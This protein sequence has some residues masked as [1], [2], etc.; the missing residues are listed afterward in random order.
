MS[1]GVTE[2]GKTFVRRQDS[3]PGDHVDLL[4]LFD[5]L[6]VPNV[7]GSDLMKTSNYSIKAVK[8]S[9]FKATAADLAKVPPVP[10]GLASQRTPKDFKIKNIKAE[11]E[12]RRDP[13]YKPEF[14][15]TPILYREYP[16]ELTEEEA[17]LLEAAR[18]PVYGD[19]DGAALRDIVFCW[20]EENFLGTM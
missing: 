1:T 13:A 4:A 19:D 6:A 18:L 17:A 12:L 2:Q 16:V 5:L 7:C 10:L 14:T 3:K 9:I 15:N 20:W 11:R 8:V